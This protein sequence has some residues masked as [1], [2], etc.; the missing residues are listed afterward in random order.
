MSEI[1]YQRLQQVL[2]QLKL[3]R[4]GECLDYVAE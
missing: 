2:Q 1:T 4:M 3:Q